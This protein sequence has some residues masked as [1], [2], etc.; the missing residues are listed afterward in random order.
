MNLPGRRIND[1]AFTYIKLGGG[2]GL[3]I[4]N[5]QERTLHSQGMTKG[6]GE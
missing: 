5:G 3:R 2:T 6:F 4:S 1:V